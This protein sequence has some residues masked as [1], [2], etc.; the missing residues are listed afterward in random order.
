MKKDKSD[1]IEV[2]GKVTECFKGGKFLV[3]LD[4]GQDIT[5]Y[6]SGRMKKFRI[7][8]LL[9]DVVKVELS[10]YDLTIGRITFRSK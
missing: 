8:V 4:S 2:S 9:G 5:A 1:V 3:H 10:P 6:L 7:R